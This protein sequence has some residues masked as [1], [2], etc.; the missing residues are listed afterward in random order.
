MHSLCDDIFVPSGVTV[1]QKL[2]KLSLSVAP[3]GGWAGGGGDVPSVIFDVDWPALQMLK[4]LYIGAPTFICQRSI[5]GLATVKQ[6]AHITWGHSAPYDAQS[7]KCF[8][9]LMYKL[10]E[11]THSKRV[12]DHTDADSV[13]T[14]HRT[15]ESTS[16]PA[17]DFRC[18]GWFG[19]PVFVM[20]CPCN[21]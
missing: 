2:S 14:D 3:H 20:W 16:I 8:A 1:L 18:L 6:L 21:P 10:A 5:V 12:A 17:P 9:A 4:S 19:A 7:T 11:D 15:G 13:T